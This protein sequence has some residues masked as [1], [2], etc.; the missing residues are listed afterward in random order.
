MERHFIASPGTSQAIRV[1]SGD[2]FFMDL[3]EETSSGYRWRAT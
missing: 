1:E 3:D 2:R